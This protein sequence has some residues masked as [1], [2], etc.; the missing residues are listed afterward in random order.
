MARPP[1]G[2]CPHFSIYVPAPFRRA[3]LIPFIA[4]L[5]WLGVA[6]SLAGGVALNP[7]E[8]AIFNHL[9]GEPDQQRAF[10]HLDPT[11]CA[12]ARARAAD[13]GQRGYYDHTDPDGHGPNWWVEQAGYTLPAG[14]D[15]SSAG[16]NIES[17]AAAYT[18]PN[19]TWNAWMDSAPHR[20]HLLATNSFFVPQ[21]SVGIGFVH[22]AASEWKTYWVVITAPPNGPTLA[23]ISPA[24]NEKL[25]APQVTLTGASGGAPAAA[26]VQ[27]RVEN[28]AWVTASGVASWSVTLTGLL[29]GDNV[30]EVRS[31]AAAGLVLDEATRTVRYVVLSPLLVQINGSG[32]V[33]EG[34]AG[35][36]PREIGRVYTITA[37]PAP[38]WLF[39]SW[40]GSLASTGPA[41]SFTMSEGLA[42][43]ANFI[44]NPFI[45]AA[46]RHTGLFAS[47]DLRGQ[48]RV[49]LNA[50]GSFTARLR[51]NGLT[52]SLAGNFDLNGNATA[53]VPGSA[54]LTLAL[55][56]DASGIHASLTDGTLTADFDL[57]ALPAS[58]SVASPF[59]GRYTLVIPA[60]D[61]ATT[62][63]PDGD[64]FATL[65]V[66]PNGAATLNGVLADGTKFLA[67]GSVSI[68]GRLALY[69]PLYA[70]GGLLTGVLNF[71]DLTG[72]DADGTLFWS[73]PDAFA[74]TVGAVASR[75]TAPA[76]GQPVLT[77]PLVENNV[78]LAL[79]DGDLAAPVS[80]PATLSADNS[81]TLAPGTTLTLKPA[82]GRFAGEFTHPLTGAPVKFRGVILQKQNAGFGFF[83]GPATSGYATFAPQ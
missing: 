19:D 68:T 39:A 6:Q 60:L 79:G 67:G 33:T 21:T 59:A 66:E 4:L 47:G 8:Q 72:S 56:L 23:I 63:T 82:S 28:G 57:D 27:A 43:T 78:A 10:L 61:D 49:K 32:S 2:K 52:V 71:R 22:D 11:L 15:H 24:Q 36:T 34:F 35:T 83:P 44:P 64:G 70:D 73:R 65:I 76:S 46:G 50:T 69:L 55:H 18:D 51:Y 37:A 13:M 12:V 42:L 7:Q 30:L 9:I 80:Q 62:T 81:V 26:S 17:I 31:L 53:T 48:C 58:D 16:N 77:V 5:A 45:A 41:I 54:P 29:P 74:I 20:Q 38:G 14:Y 25:T 75:Y 40:S 1:L 3:L